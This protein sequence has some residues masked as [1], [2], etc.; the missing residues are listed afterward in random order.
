[1]GTHARACH[2]SLGDA[3]ALR[4]ELDAQRKRAADVEEMAAAVRRDSLSHGAAANKKDEDAYDVEA[5][6][7]S[8]G[9]AASVKP[10]AGL[11]RKAPAPFNHVVVLNAARRLDRVVAVLDKRPG[12]RAGLLLYILLLHFY[13]LLW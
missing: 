10:I 4:N 6:G 13:V 3:Q 12:A 11:V 2:G 8:A 9:N 5:G 1:M 7:P